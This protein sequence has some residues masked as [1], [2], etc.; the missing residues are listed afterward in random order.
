[1]K[2]PR[3]NTPNIEA[4]GSRPPAKREFNPNANI[5]KV[6][7]KKVISNSNLTF[8]PTINIAQYCC[9]LKSYGLSFYYLPECPNRNCY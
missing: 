4:V 2:I 3:H 5:A 7:L 8:F 6:K 1:M 9:S